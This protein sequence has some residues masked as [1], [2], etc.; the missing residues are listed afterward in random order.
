MN[1]ECS[2][3]ALKVAKELITWI[4]EDPSRESFI[5]RE[6]PISK[7]TLGAIYRG[8]YVPGP[9]MVHHIRHAIKRYSADGLE[10][11]PVAAS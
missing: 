9:K 7:N 1:V 3:E 10:A 6:V 4:G 11:A 2:L 5:M 8:R